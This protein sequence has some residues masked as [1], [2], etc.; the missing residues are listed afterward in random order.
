MSQLPNPSTTAALP[1]VISGSCDGQR[2]TCRE[3]GVTH[4][5]LTEEQHH[6]LLDRIASLEAWIAAGVNKEATA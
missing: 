6:R 1:N 5:L 4:V 2:L 3:T